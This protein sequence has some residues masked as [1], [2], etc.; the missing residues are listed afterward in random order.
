MNL[1]SLFI[2]CGATYAGNGIGFEMP[3]LPLLIDLTIAIVL[4]M[5]PATRAQIEQPASLATSGLPVN[6]NILSVEAGPERPG[7][8]HQQ[9]AVEG[10]L[11]WVVATLPASIRNWNDRLSKGS[12]QAERT[13]A[14]F[15]DE[16]VRRRYAEDPRDYFLAQQNRARA[17]LRSQFDPQGFV[18]VE[19]DDG[20]RTVWL[21]FGYP[22]ARLEDALGFPV[23]ARPKVKVSTT[24]PNG[25]GIKVAPDAQGTATTISDS[26]WELAW[27]TGLVSVAVF[28]LL[29]AQATQSR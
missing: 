10:D 20:G 23:S 3:R 4:V 27:L 8:A 25:G 15:L 1:A 5:A 18:K 13:L 11:V 21:R 24:L 29:F 7:W 17:R 28:T 9:V 6:T 19:T 14:V 12:S 26:V 16:K 22:V 2:E